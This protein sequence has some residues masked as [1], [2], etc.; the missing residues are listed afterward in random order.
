MWFVVDGGGLSIDTS[1]RYARN[2]M[3]F[4][5]VFLLAKEVCL[6][7]MQTNLVQFALGRSDTETNR[8]KG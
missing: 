8:F 6:S 2:S 3:I 7:G 4:F 1:A 5:G